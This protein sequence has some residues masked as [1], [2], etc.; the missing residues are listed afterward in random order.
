MGEFYLQSCIDCRSKQQQ[1]PNQSKQFI[2]HSEI[3]TQK[4]TD[5]KV[6]QHKSNLWI[7]VQCRH[8][9]LHNSQ[10]ISDLNICTYVRWIKVFRWTSII[11]TTMRYN[12]NEVSISFLSIILLFPAWNIKVAEAPTQ[13][14][15]PPAC[16]CARF[17]ANPSMRREAN[18]GPKQDHSRH[19]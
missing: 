2:E 19:G 6:Q 17:W 18:Q 15:T 10:Y 3:T 9:L 13:C 4:T 1:L 7:Q 14:E 8:L 12:S 16:P 11:T 5:F